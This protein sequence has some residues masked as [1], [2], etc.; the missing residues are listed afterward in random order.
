MLPSRD[1]PGDCLGPAVTSEKEQG[2]FGCVPRGNGRDWGFVRLANGCRSVLLEDI[3]ENGMRA[4]VV[5]I[6]EEWSEM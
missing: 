6:D 2:V 4:E 5:G 1:R 3:K